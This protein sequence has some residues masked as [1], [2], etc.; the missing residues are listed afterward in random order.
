MEFGILNAY[1]GVDT[2]V[3]S[4]VVENG[5][6]S[7]SV[8]IN[9][10][11]ASITFPDKELAVNAIR[12]TQSAFGVI[13][14]DDTQFDLA[15]SMLSLFASK[16]YVLPKPEDFSDAEMEALM[17]EQQALDADIENYYLEKAGWL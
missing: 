1:A 12:V 14:D 2:P 3:L 4:G 5:I 6:V 17:V 10:A 13:A 16:S 9:G 8:S 7:V 11:T 15:V